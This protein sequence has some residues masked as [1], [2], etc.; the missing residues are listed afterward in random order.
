MQMPVMDGYTAVRSVRQWEADS[1]RRR[2]PIVALTASALSEDV[3]RCLG[4]GCDLHVS[5]PVRKA[6]LLEVVR[7]TTM[8]VNHQGLPENRSAESLS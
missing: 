8:A 7:R 4:A 6:T 5:K 2:T 1:Q 3:S